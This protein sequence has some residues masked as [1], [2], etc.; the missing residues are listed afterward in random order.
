MAA[1]YPCNSSRDVGEGDFGGSFAGKV[2]DLAGAGGELPFAGDESDAE[3]AAVG[4]LKLLADFFGLGEELRADP[5]G[6]DCLSDFQIGGELVFVE[7]HDQ[8]GGGGAD[9]FNQAQLFERRQ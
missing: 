9:F 6:A 8:D 5:G 2:F 7:I 4:V 1:Q 3:A